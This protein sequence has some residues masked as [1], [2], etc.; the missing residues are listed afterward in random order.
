MY[1]EEL[2]LEILLR[3]FDYLPPNDLWINFRAGNRDLFMPVARA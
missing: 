2:P 3:I 1:L